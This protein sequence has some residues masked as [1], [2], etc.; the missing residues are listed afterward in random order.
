MYDP[1]MVQP[2][3]DEVVNAGFEEAK[4]A[5]DVNAI[6]NSNP[7]STLFFVNSVCGCAAG[8]ARPGAVEAMNAAI[9]PERIVTGF[10]G[11]DVDG[12]NAM[13]ELMVGYPPSSP[14]FAL[15]R[16]NKLVHMIE[17]TDIEG[18]SAETIGNILKTAFA[19]YCGESIDDSA[20]IFNPMADLVLSAETAKAMYDGDDK[21]AMLDVREDYEIEAGSIEGYQKV[22]NE[23][24]QEIIST[25]PKDRSIVVYCQ[26]GVRSVQAVQY[27]RGQGFTNAYSLEGGYDAWTAL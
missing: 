24:A 18:Q 22:T 20:A 19:K 16:E 5:E 26:H 13:R 25:W 4:T 15:F 17:R 9:K 2:M 27:L 1:A 11:N 14:C 8:T 21:P 12:V 6:V 10:A 3:R 23:L 7:K